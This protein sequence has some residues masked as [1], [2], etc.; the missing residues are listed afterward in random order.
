MKRISIFVVLVFLMVSVHDVYAVNVPGLA[1]DNLILNPW[2]RSQANLS[3]PGLDYWTD[4]TDSP[5]CM[6]T[7]QKDNNLDPTP[8]GVVPTSARWASGTGQGESTPGCLGGLGGV[9]GILHQ[10]VQSDPSKRELNFQF[11][12]VTQYN[13]LSFVSI[14]G[15]ENQDGPWTYLWTPWFS[16]EHGISAFSHTDLYTKTLPFGFPFYKVVFTGR[17]PVGNNQGFKF[18]GV[19]FTTAFT[20]NP[21]APLSGDFDDDW[22]V[23]VI[24]QETSF[25]NQDIYRYNETISNFGTIITPPFNPELN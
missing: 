1:Q 15:S 22:D 13:E 8:D 24:D 25:Q 10:V 4:E 18:T 6:S 20:E 5:Y 7:S 14:Y 2:F 17:Y 12:Y 23:D 11:Y 21:S 9:D 3:Q 16:T 19:Y